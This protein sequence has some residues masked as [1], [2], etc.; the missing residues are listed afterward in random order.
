MM[1][2]KNDQRNTHRVFRS[3]M[4]NNVFTSSMSSGGVTKIVNSAVRS[5]DLVRVTVISSLRK[6]QFRHLICISILLKMSVFAI[7]RVLLKIL[8]FLFL[9]FR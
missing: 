8:V 1:M 6:I 4:Q 2:I 3:E 5:S 9:L 7:C